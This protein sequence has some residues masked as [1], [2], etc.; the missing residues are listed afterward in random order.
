MITLSL[1]ISPCPNDVYIF[2]GSLLGTSDAHG[3][4]FAPVRFED[5]ETLNAVSLSG[6]IDVCK[7]SYANY[8]RIAD[9]YDLLPCGGALGR[10]VGPL[11]LVNDAGDRNGAGVLDPSRELLVPG[12]W[13]TANFLLDFYFGQTDV[14]KRFVPFDALYTELCNRPEAQGVVIHEKRFTYR[15]DG[16]T[17]IQ[18]LGDFWEQK[19]G[20]AIPLGAIAVRRDL[21]AGAITNIEEAIKS[22]LRWA[23]AH[24]DDA[25]ALCRRYAQDL[26]DGVIEAHI[27]LYVNEFSHDLGA[28]GAAA[29]RYF[30]DAAAQRDATRAGIG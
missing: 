28:D 5:V 20:Q 9:Q 11:L 7:I 19:T 21:G 17:L 12:E 15:D 14:P 3:V 2:A 13:T 18:D 8:P 24:R 22:S 25:L 1:G 23:D 6:D 16:L 4:R 26:S 29:V 27:A 30:L 10:G